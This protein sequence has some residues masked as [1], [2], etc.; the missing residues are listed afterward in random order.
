MKEI[1]YKQRSAL[2]AL[3][4]GAP[5]GAMLMLLL[6]VQHI[7]IMK[8]CIFYLTS[9]ECVIQ[10]WMSKDGSTQV[11]NV[12]KANLVYVGSSLNK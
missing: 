8:F 12:L 4:F 9:L 5:T 10:M 7:P 1:A 11:V 2:A 3:L 6:G